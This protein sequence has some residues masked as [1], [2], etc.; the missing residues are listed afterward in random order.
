MAAVE[1]ALHQW[2]GAAILSHC[3]QHLNFDTVEDWIKRQQGFYIGGIVVKI[4]HHVH[5]NSLRQPLRTRVPTN[6]RG[7]LTFPF[8]DPIEPL[9]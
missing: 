4:L 1:K 8:L 6:E 5:R 3:G 7:L 2:L 9:L